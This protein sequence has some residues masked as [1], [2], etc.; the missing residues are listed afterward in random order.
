MQPARRPRLEN[1]EELALEL[2][3][4]HGVQHE[5]EPGG[6]QRDDERSQQDRTEQA[7]RADAGGPE[8]HDLQVARHPAAGE[9]HRGQEGH[10]ERVGQE[11]RQHEDEELDDEKEGYPFRDDE[12]GELVDPVDDEEEGE[13]RAPEREW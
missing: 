1:S 9:E 12:V 11:R 2:A 13:Q 8:G 4:R 3:V 10:R 7:Q 6:G 5:R